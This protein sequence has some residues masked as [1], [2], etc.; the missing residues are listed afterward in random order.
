[1][2]VIIFGVSGAGKTTVGELL[3]RELDWHFYEADESR[4]ATK[5]VRRF[6]GTT[7]G[8]GGANDR[9][10]TNPARTCEGNQSKAAADQQGLDRHLC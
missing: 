4:V 8:G 7:A 6:G 5:S 2:V 3:T 1:M 10:G 9:V